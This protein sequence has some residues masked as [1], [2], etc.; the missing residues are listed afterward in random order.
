MSPRN[1]NDITGGKGV[2]IKLMCSNWGLRITHRPGDLDFVID[3][4][5]FRVV[6]RLVVL[7]RLHP[8]KV[9]RLRFGIKVRVFRLFGFTSVKD[10]W[11]DLMESFSG[12]PDFEHDFEH[13]TV[14]LPRCCSKNVECG[15]N[16]FDVS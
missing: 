1:Y 8:R 10:G 13:F 16:E 9:D 11:R 15:I 7:E 5:P 6:I 4:T 2:V 3:I 12:I 14:N